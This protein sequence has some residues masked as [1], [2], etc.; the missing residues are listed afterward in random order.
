MA[1][2]AA[3]IFDQP[4]TGHYPLSEAAWIAG[5]QPRRLSYWVRRGYATASQSPSPPLLFCYQ[6]IAE[7]MLIHELLHRHVPWTEIK[8]MLEGLLS[9]PN[10]W[11]LSHESLS[12]VRAPNVRRAALVRNKDGAVYHREGSSWQQM[13]NPKLLGLIANRM[14]RGGWAVVLDPSIKHISIDPDYLSG[15]PRISGHRIAAVD[16]ATLAENPAGREILLRD[17][18]LRPVEIDDAVKWWQAVHRAHRAA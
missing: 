10:R 4:P 8:G 14:R 18:R 2:A 3:S 16:V 5:L 13:L 17:Y 9:G 15:R 1:A 7:A 12:T 6:D 11:P